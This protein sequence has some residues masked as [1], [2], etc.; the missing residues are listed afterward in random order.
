MATKPFH[1]QKP[2]EL[3]PDTTEYKLITKDSVKTEDWNKPCTLRRTKPA[4]GHT[5]GR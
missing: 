2:F 4:R 3:G 1:Y 5:E